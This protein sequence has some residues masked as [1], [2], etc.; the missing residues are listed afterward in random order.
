MSFL[1]PTRAREDWRWSELGGI[2]AALLAQP[3]NDVLPDTAPWRV[4][5]GPCWVFV[6][7]RLVDGPPHDF[8]TIEE[9]DGQPLTDGGRARGLVLTLGA[10]Q[11]AGPIEIIHVATGGGAQL[12]HRYALGPDATATVAETYIALGDGAAWVNVSV[13]VALAPG[14]RLLRAVRHLEAAATTTETVSA[15]VAAGAH[16]AATTLL[17]GGG[18][19][20]SETHVSLDG[21][22]AFAS[23]DG[24]ILAGGAARADVF[25]RILHAVP[26]T[27]S[28]QTWRAVARDAATASIAA[29]VE[30]ARGADGSDAVQSIKGLLFDRTATINAKPEL[31]IFAD[32]V[33]AAHGCA[34]GELDP[35]ALFYLAQRGL[36]P[37]AARALMTRAFVAGVLDGCGDPAARAALQADATAWLEQA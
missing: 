34:I 22:G 18:A 32:D 37:A 24:A 21:A 16:Y 30:V 36:P 33:K 6:D 14:A 31:E 23:V 19:A 25:T 28:R 3:A 5:D 9:R 26:D 2:A 1:L 8:A 12:A 35:A 27:T 11:A 10:G 29:R 17:A 20:R 13:E 4:G 15:H 7:G